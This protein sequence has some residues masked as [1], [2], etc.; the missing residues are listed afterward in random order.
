MLIPRQT[1]YDRWSDKIIEMKMKCERRQSKGKESKKIADLRKIKKKIRK[2]IGVQTEESDRSLQRQRLQMLT[3]HIEEE[4]LEENTRKLVK[5]VK[6]LQ[7][8]PGIISEN[9]FWKFQQKQKNKLKEQKTAMKN[10]V[11]Y[12]LF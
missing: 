9:T 1:K 7:K 5:T 2:N 11:I 10:K 3:R 6:S 12:K 8:A 4:K